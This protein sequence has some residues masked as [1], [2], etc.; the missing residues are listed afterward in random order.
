MI[1]TLGVLIKSSYPKYSHDEVLTYLEVD[2]E[3]RNDPSEAAGAD[4]NDELRQYQAYLELKHLL[5]DRVRTRRNIKSEE[6][7]ALAKN[8]PALYQMLGDE[9][10]VRLLALDDRL[11]RIPRSHRIRGMVLGP[12]FSEHFERILGKVKKWH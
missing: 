1:V 5:V 8:A 7:D 6:W 3:T 9:E 4:W 10:L 2:P 12:D 11:T